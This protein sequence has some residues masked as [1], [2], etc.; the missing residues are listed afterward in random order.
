[1]IGKKNFFKCRTWLIVI[2]RLEAQAMDSWD[3]GIGKD[4]YFKNEAITVTGLFD[5]PADKAKATTEETTRV[6]LREFRRLISDKSPIP[7]M[8]ATNVVY[9]RKGAL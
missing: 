4:Q 5:D 8:M 1:L 7:G 3:L 2:E 6:D 9:K